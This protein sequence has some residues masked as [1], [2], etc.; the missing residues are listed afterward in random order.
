MKTLFPHGLF[1]TLLVASLVISVR[2][3]AQVVDPVSNEEF[4][5]YALEQFATVKNL[6]WLAIAAVVVQIVIKFAGTPLFSGWFKSL[7]GDTKFLIVSI[8]SSIA[9]VLTLVVQ[10]KFSWGA[11]LISSTAL[12]SYSVWGHQAWSRWVSPWLTKLI[13]KK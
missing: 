3:I 2:V 6:S 12:A 9:A 10:Q 4:F 13:S 5:R 7:T 1:L 8:L 11:A